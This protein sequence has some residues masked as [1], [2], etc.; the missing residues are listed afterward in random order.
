MSEV[1]IVSSIIQVALNPAQPTTQANAITCLS[2]LAQGI[3]FRNHI[4]LLG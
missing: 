1:E 3:N 2:N 4:L